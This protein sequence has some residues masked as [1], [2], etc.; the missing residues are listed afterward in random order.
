MLEWVCPQCDRQVDPGL[1]VCPFC[2]GKEMA[3]AKPARVRRAFNWD[4]VDR[5]FRFGLGFVAVLALVYFLLFLVAYVWNHEELL[6]H[7]M[8]WLYGR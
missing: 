8:R 1:E 4:D 6:I 7:L 2:G 5:G 3:A